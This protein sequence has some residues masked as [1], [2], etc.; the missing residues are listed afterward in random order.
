MSEH[1]MVKGGSYLITKTDPQD[2]FTP[3]DFDE[4]HLMIHQMSKDFNDN[5]ILEKVEEI[6]AMEEGVTTSLLKKA[7]ELGLLSVDIPEKYGGD[8]AD[9]ISTL[10]VTENISGCGSFSTA[11]GA[12]TGIG[13]LPIVFFGT[14][15]QKQ[16]YLPGLATGE[17]IAAYALTEPEAG[18]DAL[19][20]KT[21]AE[22]SEDGKYY[23][24][25]GSK[26]WISNASWAD[27]IVTYAKIDGEK[28]TA[29]IVDG[30]APGLSIDPEETKMGLKGS[31]TCS[32]IFDDC[33]VPVENML[34]QEGKGHQV[35][36]NILNIGRFKL[37][38]GCVGAA[39][40]VLALSADYAL[41]REQ[42][43]RPIA[44]FGLIKNKIADMAIQTYVTES[45][46]YRTGGLIED[47]LSSMDL[48]GEDAG[49]KIADGIQEYAIECSV[50]KV[51]GSEAFD[52]VVDEGVQI[53]G[54]YG[55]SQEY[56]VERAY[57]D[58][59]VNR[60]FEGTNEINRLIIPATLMRKAMK[61]EIELIQAAQ[62][63]QEEL[64]MPMMADIPDEPLAKE[65]NL[66]E[67]MKKLFLMVAGTA[68]QKYGE[69]IQK[70]QEILAVIADMAIQVFAAESAL[71]RARKIIA[72]K[73]E[74]T[75]AL[76][77]KMTE[78]FVDEA[79]PKFDKW[80]KD[81]IAAME[82]GDT[83]RTLLSAQRKL[84]RFEPINIYQRKRE[85]ADEMLASKKYFVLK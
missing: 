81:A 44:K 19:N 78:C 47:L 67:N 31:S 43:G 55:Y 68:V 12:H 42:F 25:N 61:G 37:G 74:E 71:L 62:K 77:I 4:T 23:I 51:F 72:N 79:M 2:V 35:A 1:E 58:S 75:A 56:A 22:L 13:T 5:M 80:G 82:E 50:N 17:K 53:Y 14:E 32:L 64:M 85:I 84:S 59:R 26:M 57:R 6:E 10:I 40:N 27:V 24:L 49:K 34:W 54:G 48:E 52:F 38:A 69:A 41:Q 76:A 8:E 63:L 46:I 83:Q 3:E 70:E 21:R 73:G 11:F 9:K 29:F 15:E 28:F 18:S 65:E 66:V 30:D 20:S 33:K 60:I 16:K 7:G 36:F 39:K 45:M